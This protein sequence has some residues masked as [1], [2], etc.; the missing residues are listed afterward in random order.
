MKPRR[1]IAIL[2]AGAA[3]SAGYYA[4]FLP[5][6][7]REAGYL[8]AELVAIAL[9]V[10]GIRIL[11]P[12]RP[13]AWILIAVGMTCVALGDMTWDWL[14]RVALELPS[15]SLADFFYLA[16][17][18]FLVVG[19]FLMVRGRS[20]RATALDTLGFT[21]GIAVLIWS[22]L[23]EP[24]LADSTLSTMELFL[25]A[26]Y[27]IADVA[28]IAAVLGVFLG[29]R[30]NSPSIRLLALG[31]GLTF[32]ADVLYLRWELVGGIP[33]PS[34]F[35]FAYPLSM[36]IW[37]AALFHPSAVQKST[38]VSTDWLY[39]RTA[40]VALLG[41][42]SLLVPLAVALDVSDGNF[43]QL[44]LFLIAWVVLVAI[45]VLRTNDA[46]DQAQHSEQRFRTIFQTSPAGVGIARG[47]RILD[48][49]ESVRAMFGYAD[50]AALAEVPVS[51]HVAL[52]ERDNFRVRQHLG[53]AGGEVAMAFE[54]VATRADGSQFPL[55]VKAR[56]IQLS[57]GPATVG[58]FLDLSEQRAAEERS[59]SS[60]QHY[61]Q[62]FE[63]NPHVM[64]IYDLE[65]LAFLA[66]NDQ[67]I[68]TY[69]WSRDEF[70]S[71]TILDVRPAEQIPAL[72]ANVREC[73]EPLQTSGPWTHHRK[74]G[75]FV[76]V[77][78][79]SNAIPWEGR[80]ARL[81]LIVDITERGRL[82]EQLR[83]A[84][85]MEAV[86]RLAG[87]VAHDFNNLLTAISGYGHLLKSE[88]DS[89]D[90]RQ[91]DVAEILNASER[92]AAL[93]RQLLTFSRRQVLD[94]QVLDPNEAVLATASMIRRL[95]G[96]DVELRTRM[97][98]KV[99][100]VLIDQG[101]LSQVLV[102]L[103]VNARDAMPDGGILTIE[104][105]NAE[106]PVGA[107][108]LPSEGRSKPFVM[109]A[110]SDTGIGMDAETQAHLFE[111]FFTTKPAGLGTG[112]G[113]ATVYGIIRGS[114]GTIEVRSELG[115]GSTFKIYLPAILEQHAPVVELVA[116]AGPRPA[117]GN[118]TVLVVEDEELVRRFVDYLLRSNGYRVLAASNPEEGG[119]IVA[120]YAE[121]IDLLV[122]DVVM[123]GGNGAA[124]AEWV[125]S[126]RPDVRVL[127]MS[128]YAEDAI[129]HHG[130][131]DEGIAFIAKPFGPEAFL[132]KVR[133]TIESPAAR[134]TR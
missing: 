101:Q 69:G 102:N 105:A 33:D 2:V 64:W 116:K 62:L 114:D 32:L 31:L 81:A 50:T 17:Y 82:E 5:P 104:T 13:V 83:Q 90:S 110:V 47:D 68:K 38:Q 25:D 48:A 94:P 124:F 14:S 42:G 61:R 106:L 63:S 40:R 99:A 129:V 122:T 109:L 53:S 3:V 7:L 23:V 115:Q 20:Y 92:A 100:S 73:T 118:E 125:T 70:L 133:E 6:D 84:Q 76:Q 37:A 132:K 39:R 67:A 8:A 123:P 44:P 119:S 26:I 22:L 46:L 112:L 28:L 77:E 59:R 86:G 127:F 18:P 51:E 10:L 96:E 57:D 85:K 36:F 89:N 126:I 72:L 1:W 41:A 130:V 49:N 19:G 58:F 97:D 21:I 98:A 35:D 113:L 107:T 71:M 134:P 34:P 78:V 74:D 45:M 43:S 128:G 60:E 11:K 131:V 108:R 103:V 66:V 30:L 9:L 16:E 52:T 91:A 54:T 55:M 4:P 93:T 29:S 56:T 88:L 120:K 75:T 15:P 12:D 87:G 24:Y 79:T 65:T 117:G 27:P 121:Q 111:P 95:I 80:S